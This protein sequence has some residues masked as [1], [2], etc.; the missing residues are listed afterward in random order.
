[1]GAVSYTTENL[2]TGEGDKEQPRCSPSFMRGPWQ[3]GVMFLQANDTAGHIR[4]NP[5]TTTQTKLQLDY[6]P[7]DKRHFGIVNLTFEMNG[8]LWILVEVLE[9]SQPHNKPPW[10]N[11]IIP[12]W[13]HL[14]TKTTQ[15]T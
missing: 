14:Q 7:D 13:A 6:E 11:G 15:Q 8:K 4:K 9:G 10:Q 1:M 12:N 3:D 5:V 2:E